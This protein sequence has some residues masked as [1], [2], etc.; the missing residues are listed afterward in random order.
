MALF[1]LAFIGGYCA[2]VALGCY[3]IWLLDGED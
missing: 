3:L 1:M 2:F